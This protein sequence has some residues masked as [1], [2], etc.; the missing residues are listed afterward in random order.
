MVSAE[1]VTLPEVAIE[2]MEGK[3][4]K[5]CAFKGASFFIL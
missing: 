4:K 2:K 1:T 5:A 3:R